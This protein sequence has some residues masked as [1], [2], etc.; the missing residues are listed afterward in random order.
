MFMKRNNFTLLEVLCAMIILTMGIS[1]L[2]WQLTT[3]IKRLEQNQSSWEQTHNLTQAAEYL[4]I[5]GDNVPLSQTLFTGETQISYFYAE[6]ELKLDNLPLSRRN[7][8]KLTIQLHKDGKIIDE[9]V[10]D[11]FVEETNHAR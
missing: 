9:L 8:K 11:T 2:M 6:S 1:L 10:M 3:A 5:H 7:L 4:L